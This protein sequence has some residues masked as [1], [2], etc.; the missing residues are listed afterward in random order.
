[1]KELE[2]QIND[3]RERWE[4]NAEF[5]DDYMGDNSNS[6]H[7]EIVRPDTEKLLSIQKDD[8]ILDIACGN[9]NFSKRLA[10]LGAEVVA[11][12]YSSKMIKRAKRRCH[13]YKDRISFS[14]LDATDYNSL[15]DLG[16]DS[17]D[18][19]VANM[20][21]MDIATIDPLLKAVYDLLKYEGLFVFSIMH[22]CFQPPGTRKVYEE[23]EIENKIVAKRSIQIFKYIKPETYEG[24]GIRN[25]PVASRYFHRSLSDLLNICFDKGFV[26][27]GISEPTF[28]RDKYKDSDFEWIDI[29]PAIIIRLKKM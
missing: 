22:P 25:Q 26:M 21:L 2:N 24:V 13:E 16:K 29:P 12:D 28:D 14:V 15:V 9:G 10:E 11:F 5:W 4:I 3:S 20:A 19:A 8:L 1:M 27:D 17:F 7:R 23:E 6:F 18:K